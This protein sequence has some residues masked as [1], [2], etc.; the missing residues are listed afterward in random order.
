MMD[1]YKELSSTW[2]EKEQ[3]F[4][5]SFVRLLRRIRQFNWYAIIIVRKTNPHRY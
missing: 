2:L 3:A 1:K 5:Y 4:V